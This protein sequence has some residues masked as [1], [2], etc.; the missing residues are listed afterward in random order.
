MWDF[1]MFRYGCQAFAYQM[2][3]YKY[4]LAHP[5]FGSYITH[6]LARVQDK[7]ANTSVQFFHPEYRLRDQGIWNK[8]RDNIL[9]LLFGKQK[10]D[11][12]QGIRY[13]DYLAARGWTP[14]TMRQQMREFFEKKFHTHPFDE[15]LG[16]G[17]F[18]L[19]K[20]HDGNVHSLQDYYWDVTNG[21][22][23]QF[24]LN[25]KAFLLGSPQEMLVSPWTDPAYFNAYIILNYNSNDQ[26]IQ[27]LRGQYIGGAVNTSGVPAELSR[28]EYMAFFPHHAFKYNKYESIEPDP[29]ID[30][31]SELNKT[32]RG[33]MWFDIYEYNHNMRVR[34]V[35]LPDIHWYTQHT[36]RFKLYGAA[37]LNIRPDDVELYKVQRDRTESSYQQE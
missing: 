35:R 21:G 18:K 10:Y 22:K 12:Y 13:T 16:V 2:P 15:T 3:H 1:W 31:Y 5:W 9:P 37:I 32:E 36:R 23:A 8:F 28:G 19:P 24:I 17:K 7:F 20:C 14:I 4:A 33:F 26:A 30:V 34:P 29:D 11:A 6:M 25:A 27:S